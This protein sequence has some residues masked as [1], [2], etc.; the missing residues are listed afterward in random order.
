VPVVVLVHGAEN[1]SARDSY[2]LQRMFPAVGIGAFVYDKRGTGDSSGAYTHD[3]L[4]LAVDAI[5]AAR[6]ARRLAGHRLARIGY[7]AGSQGGWVAPLASAIEPVDFV[8][9]G[10]GLAVSPLRAERELIALD[11]Q[12]HGY[13]PEEVDKAM[14]VADAVDAIVVSGF[15][16]GY[17]QFAAV[18]RRYQRQP[19]FPHVQGS[20]TA[21]ILETPP[22]VLR[23]EG[24]RRVPGVPFHYDPMA[25][26]RNLD[27]PQ[28]WILGGD[29][30]VAPAPETGR[31]LAALAESGRPI[32]TAVYPGADHGIYYYETGSDGGR[33]STRAPAGYFPMMREFALDGR[34]SGDHGAEILSR[35]ARRR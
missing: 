34:L 10:F 20:I 28:L 29:D 35:G 1:T 6:E 31:R 17:E 30:L 24:P 15:Q 8:I 4:T 11:V 16:S 32:T 19:W 14:D 33:V 27:T 5:A 22:E 12:H 9:V 3:Y 7:Q 26:L 23:I 13:G 21:V 25:V 2:A 18:R